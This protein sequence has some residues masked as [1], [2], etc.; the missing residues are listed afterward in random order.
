MKELEYI[1]VRDK[2]KELSLNNGNGLIFL[3]YNFENTTDVKEFIYDDSVKVVNKLWRNENINIER[4]ENDISETKYYQENDITWIGP[5]VFIAYTFWS[6]NQNLM[7][8]SLSV[9]ANYLTDFFKGKTGSPKIKLEYIVEKNP[10]TKSKNV[11]FS[12]E[13]DI[14]G[15]DKL[16]KILEKLKDE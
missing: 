5:T 7:A 1:N 3:P 10:K 13:G 11:R 9:V 14:Q 12:Y 6:E 8:I 16:P 2:I 15:L 4:L